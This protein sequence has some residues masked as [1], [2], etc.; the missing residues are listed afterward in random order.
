MKMQENNTISK[1][2]TEF[3]EITTRA[4]LY[5]QKID[6]LHKRIRSNNTHVHKSIRLLKI[7]LLHLKKLKMMYKQKKK[8]MLET[9]IQYL[10]TELQEKGEQ[11]MQI[12]LLIEKIQLEIEN[13]ECL[14]N[15][16]Y[17]TNMNNKNIKE[18]D[19]MYQDYSNYT[20]QFAKAK[21]SVLY[22]LEILLEILEQS[23]LNK[24]NKI[25]NNKT[26]NKVSKLS[27]HKKQID[28]EA[29]LFE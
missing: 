24:A 13:L 5:K 3:K 8:D 25:E 11:Y 28:Y 15:T 4:L 22:D 19:A 10:Y 1:D 26:A 23:H 2:F 21:N 6:A 9:I 7:D 27:K 12:R 14:N 29:T 17:D 16:Y 20:K 18:N